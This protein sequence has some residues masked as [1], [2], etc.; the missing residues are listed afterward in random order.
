MVDSNDEDSLVGLEQ[1]LHAAKVSVRWL[2]RTVLADPPMLHT[3]ACALGSAFFLDLLTKIR[4]V[5]V[6]QGEFL[7]CPLLTR[8]RPRRR[9][10][11]GWLAVVAF[12]YDSTIRTSYFVI[13][14]YDDTI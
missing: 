14:C 3:L 8:D 7:S 9:L 10:S 5:K 12:I 2:V 1:R 11:S 6:A 13:K 4:K